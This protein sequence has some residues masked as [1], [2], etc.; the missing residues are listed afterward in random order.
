MYEEQPSIE[1]L[2]FA[3]WFSIACK[4][5]SLQLQFEQKICGNMTGCGPH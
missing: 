4:Q 5:N 3:V 1:A 2:L